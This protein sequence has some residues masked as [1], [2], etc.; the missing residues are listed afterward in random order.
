MDTRTARRLLEQERMRLQRLLEAATASE[1][2]VSLAA[3]APG[4]SADVGG[5]II[6]REIA[7]SFHVHAQRGLREVDEAFARIAD[8]RFGVC[9]VCGGPIGRERLKVLPAT[10]ACV[11]HATADLGAVVD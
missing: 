10:R 5:R 7:E 4:D 1:D 11:A 8:N 6:E 9:D 3:A 2:A